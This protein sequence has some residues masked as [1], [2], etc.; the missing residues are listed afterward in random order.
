[1]A[2]ERSK[3]LDNI[4]DKMPKAM[5]DS[6]FSLDNNGKI[7]FMLSGLKSNTTREW[8]DIYEAIARWVYK[9]YEIR[10]DRNDSL[11]TVC[12]T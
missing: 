5:K 7:I 10:K 11:D 1:M 8:P 4:T 3:Y 12:D 6:Y 9:M 2:N